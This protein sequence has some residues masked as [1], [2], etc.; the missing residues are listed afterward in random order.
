L[1]TLGTSKVARGNKAGITSEFSLEHELLA[2]S[3]RAKYDEVDYP[4]LHVAPHPAIVEA[5]TAHEDALD[6]CRYGLPARLA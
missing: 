3:T 2:F 4:T 1:P 5:L 6:M